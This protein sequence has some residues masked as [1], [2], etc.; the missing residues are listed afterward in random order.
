MNPLVWD[1][2]ATRQL[3]HPG[4]QSP[5]SVSLSRPV[6]PS[7][8]A[9]RL[10]GVGI[11]LFRRPRRWGS[12][13]SPSGRTL[14]LEEVKELP[15]KFAN[16]AVPDDCNCWGLAALV[17]MALNW[18]I[19]RMARGMVDHDEP[20]ALA[21]A[22]GFDGVQIHGAHGYLLSQFLSPHTNRRNDAYGGSAPNRRRLLL[23][24]LAA[25][26][27]AIGT[28]CMLSVKVNCADFRVGGL[29]Q[30]EAMEL[31]MASWLQRW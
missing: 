9:F 22:A 12:L 27:V 19:Q 18:A 6:A 5:P 30:T 31:M 4:R 7:D 17:G 15:T 3:G 23:E 25:V 28:R 29:E 14:T 21:V 24:I 11:Q 8:V 10:P 1:G 16:A 13:E 20:S 26:R 2:G